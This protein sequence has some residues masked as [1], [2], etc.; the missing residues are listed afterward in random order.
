MTFMTLP[1]LLPQAP[2]VPE[3]PHRKDKIQANSYLRDTPSH[4][5]MFIVVSL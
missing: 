5:E 2:V 1:S 4:E 3:F